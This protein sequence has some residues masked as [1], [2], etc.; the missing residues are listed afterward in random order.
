MLAILNYLN[1]HNFSIFEPILMKLVSK[2]MVHSVLSNKTNLSSGLLSPLSQYLNHD[3]DCMFIVM[4][5][6]KNLK[7]A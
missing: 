7:T 3:V 6:W 1:A 2:F 4:F 5:H